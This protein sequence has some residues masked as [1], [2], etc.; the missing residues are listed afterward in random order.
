[1]SEKILIEIDCDGNE[2]DDCQFVGLSKD[3]IVCAV[4]LSNLSY[5]SRGEGVHRFRAPFR[6]SQCLSAEKK[7]REGR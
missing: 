1:M 4:W 7:A 3:E 2:C 5:V 6:C